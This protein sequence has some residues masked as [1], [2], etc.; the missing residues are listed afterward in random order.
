[1][2]GAGAPDPPARA[3]YAAG[4]S[5]TVDLVVMVKFFV[6]H[7]ALF[8]W[9]ATA[10]TALGLGVSFHA[11]RIYRAE[12]TVQPVSYAD[13]S[14]G[15]SGMR[16]LGAL[17]PLLGLQLG[18]ADSSTAASLAVLKS[19]QLLTQFIAEQ[20]LLTKILANRWDAA[21]GR[22]R[23]SWWTPTPTIEDAYERFSREIFATHENPKSGLVVVA[24]DWRDPVEAARW[25]NALIAKANS[26]IA[27]QASAE[28]DLRIK[29]L[30]LE[31]Q[32][33]D[34]VELRQAIYTL[35]EEEIKKRMLAQTSVGYAFRV[36]DPAAAPPVRE[37][38]RPM[39]I[40]YAI[41]G[42]IL[43]TLFAAVLATRRDQRR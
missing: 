13:Q 31:L 6:R 2:S 23:T 16:Q 18:G 26:F 41:A 43:G 37:Y 7:I 11:T 5:R 29:Y 40:L 39:R 30:N 8:A 24:I 20:N 12:A 25:S 3:I 9:C 34:Q 32:K 21:N 33:A 10:A 14:M 42:F 19:H 4:D 1:M 15:L 22:W 38:I 36:L 28:A 27:Q 35:I 17:S